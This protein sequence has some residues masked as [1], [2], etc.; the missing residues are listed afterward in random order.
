MTDKST[1]R[2]GRQLWER[3]T[4][5]SLG[6]VGQVLQFPGEGKITLVADDMGDTPRK[7]KGQEQ[8]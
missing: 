6:D 1:P 8:K 2:S 5:R 4:L 7:P 3:P